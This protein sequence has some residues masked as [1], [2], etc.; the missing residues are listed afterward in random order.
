MIDFLS[1]WFFLVLAIVA[2]LVWLYVVGTDEQPEAPDRLRADWSW[3][4]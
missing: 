4:D 2:A 1:S 3:R